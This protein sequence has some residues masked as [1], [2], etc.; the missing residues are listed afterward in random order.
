MSTENIAHEKRYRNWRAQY[1][2]MFAPESR[3]FQQD[4]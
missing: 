3:A 2:T 4:E 1:D